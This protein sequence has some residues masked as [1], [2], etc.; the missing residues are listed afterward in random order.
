MMIHTIKEPRR[1]VHLLFSGH[2]FKFLTPLIERCQRSELYEVRLDKHKGHQIDSEA[3]AREHLKWADIIFCEWALGNAV[4]YSQHK[5]PDQLL[6]VRL[7]LQEVQARDQISFIWETDWSAVDRLITITHHIYDW[8]VAEFPVLRDRACLIYNPID[9][10]GQL[11]QPK[12][13]GH[14]FRLGLVGVVPQRKRIDLAV[15]ILEKLVRQDQRYRLHVK[16]HRPE[17]YDWMLARKDEMAWYNELYGRIQSLP[18]Q[19]AVIFEPHGADM[20]G[21]Y[22]KIGFILSTSDFEGSHQAV[23]EGMAAGCIPII[24]NW[25]GADRIYPPKHVVE[26]MD[27]AAVMIQRWNESPYQAEEREACRRYARERFDQE[28]ICDKIESFFIE[29]IRARFQDDGAPTLPARPAQ[30]TLPRVML[31]GYIAPGYRGGYRIRI[32]QEI[33]ALTRLGCQ[34]HLACLHPPIQD[35]AAL[36]DHAAQLERLGCRVHLIPSPR[37]FDIQIASDTFKGELDALEAV[38]RAERI[39]LVHAEALYSARLGAHLKKRLPEIKLVFDVHGDS[40]EEERMSGASKERVRAMVE[41]DRLV[42]ELSDLNV[43]VSEAMREHFQARHRRELPSV[44]VPCCVAD[45]CFTQRRTGRPILLPPG[46]PVLAYLG[47]MVAWQCGDEMIGLFARLHRLNRDLF[48]LLLV[49]LGDHA[50]VRT[51]MERHGLGGEDVLLVEVPHEQVADYL[52]HAHAGLLLRLDDPVN[53]VS[54]PTKFGEYLA[55]GCPVVMTERI[56]DYSQLAREH[57]VGVVL[58]PQWLV[59]QNWPEAELRRIL[60]LVER[61]HAGRE[62]MARRCRDLAWEMIHWEPASERLALA[63]SRVLLGEPAAQMAQTAG[64]TAQR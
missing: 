43:F 48:Y 49:P 2:D 37:F 22:S 41:A 52:R 57:E 9:A 17:Q 20:A 7:H 3:D 27:Q 35:A 5:R 56:G 51:L 15:E 4:W 55:A 12:P 40:V 29:A 24:R 8:M 64:E 11:N 13:P 16:G 34:V 47:T 45:R 59:S 62:E 38:V 50:K 61:S 63:Y 18:F 19:D 33:Q 60:D 53:R 31:L 25:V 30:A 32:E 54:S 1:K 10:S 21:F 39:A 42:F 36:K 6:V 23:A 14:E 28:L 44:I 26:S 46:R 58:D